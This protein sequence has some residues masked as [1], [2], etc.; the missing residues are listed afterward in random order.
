M[1][2]IVENLYH[3]IMAAYKARDEITLEEA[4][5]IEETVDNVTDEM[6]DNHIERL[7]QGVCSPT[8]GAEF[9]SMTSDIER[10]ADHYINVGK[11][12][13]ELQ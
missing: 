12:I 10:I 6:A 3:K 7:G 9:L 4:Y 11:T 1:E 13:R 2:G 5:D 8:V